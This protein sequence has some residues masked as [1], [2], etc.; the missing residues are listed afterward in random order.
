MTSKK[1]VV[2]LANLGTPDN[3]SVP[4]VR[5][6]LAEFLSDRRVIRMSPWI[7]RPIL[8]GFILRVRPKQSAEAYKKVWTEEGSPLLTI[9]LKQAAALDAVIGDDVTVL[10]AMSYG[11]PSIKT[12]LDKLRDKVDKLIVLPLYPQYSTT[13]TA[14]T[15][16]AVHTALKSWKQAPQLEQINDYH[17][18][19]SY[20][21]AIADSVNA[22]RAENGSG[23]L[24]LFSY[25]GLPKDYLG[26]DEPYQEQCLETTRLVIE[27]LGLSE[28]EWKLTFQSRV[29]PK[30]WLS[31]YTEETIRELGKQG[32]KKIDVICPGFSA[33]CLET[34]EEIAIQNQEFFIESGGESISYIPALND[35]ETH[36]NMMKRLVEKNL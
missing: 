27:K 7:W 12:V 6:Y 14:S 20:I 4:A 22:Y 25:H 5:K 33:D 2:L 32:V 28:E 26:D 34:L 29:G 8:H 24:L 35:D 10:P 3:P 15:F 18:D 19:E 1:T 13:T 30:E 16:D 17:N 9:T 21:E 31:P 11:N 23:E 36:I